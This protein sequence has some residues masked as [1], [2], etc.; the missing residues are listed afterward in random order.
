ML[1]YTQKLPHVETTSIHPTPPETMESFIKYIDSNLNM[2]MLVITIVSSIA[3]PVSAYQVFI[4]GNHGFSPTKSTTPKTEEV[5]QNLL[6]Q[7]GDPGWP[8]AKEKNRIA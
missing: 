7:R 5:Q 6:T 8:P 3:A 2:L 4:K 1:L